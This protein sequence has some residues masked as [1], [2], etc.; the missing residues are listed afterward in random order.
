M[1]ADLRDLYQEVILDHQKSPRNFRPM[2]DADRTAEGY[3]PLCGDRVAVF[4][5]IEDGIVRDVSFQGVGCA[6]CTASASM[7]T[8]QV[9]GR[10]IDEIETLFGAFHDLV[11][12]DADES[13]AAA[14]APD[15][16]GKL[17]IF[18]G[19]RNFPIRVKCATL[20][21]HTLH[22]AMT[23]TESEVSTE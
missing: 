3:N 12:V 23:G 7:M 1:S 20:P 2:S 6:I 9:K 15:T 18:A 8:A 4:L 11:T 19:V 21:W 22:A 13:A 5:K 16:L 10:R 14:D 17:K